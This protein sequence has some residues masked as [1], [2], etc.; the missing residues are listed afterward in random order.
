[1]RLTLRL[2]FLSSLFLAAG[3]K[4]Q[5]LSL[6]LK[7]A[8]LKKVFDQIEAQTEV[9]FFYRLELLKMARKVSL[10]VSNG[11]LKDVLRRCF[12]DQPLTY[13][14]IDKTIVIKEKARKIPKAHRNPPNRPFR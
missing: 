10:S 12:Q 6:S 5:T 2:L 4:A 8:P 7:N 9:R 11:D 13:E 1:M 3:A 14:I